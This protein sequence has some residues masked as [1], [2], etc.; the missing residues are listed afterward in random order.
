MTSAH[1]VVRWNALQKLACLAL[2][3]CGQVETQLSHFNLGLGPNYPALPKGPSFPALVMGPNCPT[4]S[5]LVS[6]QRGVT[7]LQI[8]WPAHKLINLLAKVST[9]KI[10]GRTVLIDYETSTYFSH[11]TKCRVGSTWH[12]TKK[13]LKKERRVHQKIL[14]TNKNVKQKIMTIQ[15]KKQLKDVLCE[16]FHTYIQEFR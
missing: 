12:L 5:T 8:F 14:K 3:C 2:R 15:L 1:E 6:N 11:T 13:M 7:M 9:Q 16:T 10:W 4:L